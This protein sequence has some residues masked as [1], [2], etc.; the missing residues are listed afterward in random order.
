MAK[1][2]I[3]I[4]LLAL[5]KFATQYPDADLDTIEVHDLSEPD[6]VCFGFYYHDPDGD[7]NATVIR[8]RC[9]GE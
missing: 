1:V 8:V 3:R 4:W 9:D 5:S 6:S 7:Y 2:S